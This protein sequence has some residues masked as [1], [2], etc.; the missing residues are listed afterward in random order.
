[1]DLIRETL[2]NF[3]EKVRKVRRYK[4]ILLASVATMAVFIGLLVGFRNTKAFSPEKK[5]EG[6]EDVAIS[7]NELKIPTDVQVVGI[8]EATHGNHEFQTVKRD[9]LEKVVTEGNGRSLSFEMAAGDAAWINDAIHDKDADLTEA[10]GKQSYPIYG[11]PEIVELLQWMRDYNENL[12][13][14]E[15][16]MFY[17]VDIQGGMTSIV[18]MQNLCR[19]GCELFT[20]DEKAKLLTIKTEEKADYAPEREFFQGLYERL[21]A[22]E[23]LKAKQLSILAKCVVLNIDA[24][25]YDEEPQEN[26]HNR[27]L[28]MAELLKDYWNIENER[29]YDQVVITAHNGHAMKGGKS[30]L[31]S[32]GEETMGDQIN[33]IFGGSYYCIGTEFYKGDVNIHT[34]GTYD[35]NYE[36]ANHFY[37]SDDS[38]AYQAKDFENGTY[39]LDFSKVTDEN[40]KVY[41]ILNNY[42]F[43][44]EMGEGY[45]Q[46]Q[47]LG[48]SHRIKIKATDRFDAMVYYYE[49]TPIDPIYYK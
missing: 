26:G 29:G 46:L 44:G 7:F 33:R 45:G 40:S 20:E 35:D 19:E 39:C 13:Y 4:I 1:M 25:D 43:F 2:N 28:R 24:P 48:P 21:S 42:N 8:G 14:E 47:D 17:G 12:P 10:V 32:E 15:S 9:V 37:C 16:L 18:Y 6:I 34:A 23:N 38:L 36:R 27:D 49:V 11:T 5:I 41:K 3:E 22:S 30:I 31:P